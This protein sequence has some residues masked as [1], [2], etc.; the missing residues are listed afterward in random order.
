MIN[1]LP[2]TSLYVAIFALF[3]VAITLRIGLYRGANRISFGDGGDKKFLAKI[4]AQANFSES[5]PIALI[6]IGLVELSGAST[7]WV[8]G[9]FI[10]LLAGRVS[11][12]LQ[13]THVLKPLI[14]R[15]GGM[16]LTFSAIITGSIYLLLN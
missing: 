15:Q 7:T 6:V 2:I 9:L 16:I 14:F 10:T 3:F 13:L 11:H 8:H 12:Y 4:R 5:T 1:L